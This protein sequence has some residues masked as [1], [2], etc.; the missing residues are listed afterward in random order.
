M[1]DVEDSDW[2]RIPGAAS[3]SRTQG[4]GPGQRRPADTPLPL[5]HR[6]VLGVVEQGDALPLPLAAAGKRLQVRCG[7]VCPARTV[8]RD[9][10]GVKKRVCALL[11]QLAA[12]GRC[13]RGCNIL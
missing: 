5:K 12:V 1:V 13:L 11:L 10:L 8:H 3:S 7:L 9:V 2:E 6:T 4:Q